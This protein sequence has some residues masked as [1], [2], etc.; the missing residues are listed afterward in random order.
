MAKLI[1]GSGIRLME[2]LRLRVKNL[3]FERRTLIVRTAGG[4]RTG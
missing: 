1:C 4:R 3:K 2:C